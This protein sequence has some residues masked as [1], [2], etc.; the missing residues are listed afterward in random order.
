VG[1]VGDP[2]GLADGDA[3]G[4]GVGTT[5]QF[6]SAAHSSAVL[7]VHSQSL[8]DRARFASQHSGRAVGPK[9]GE[10][11][12]GGDGPLEGAAEGDALGDAEGA[13]EGAADG[14]ADG[15]ADGT[16]GEAEGDAVGVLVGNTQTSVFAENPYSAPTLLAHS[17][18]SSQCE[19]LS[20]SPSPLAHVHAVV[21]KL[22]DPLHFVLWHVGTAHT[23]VPDENS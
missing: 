3:V 21:Q 12:G 16:V 22:P 2:L 5:A 9:V 10:S 7:P 19:S 1:V 23:S 4:A 8:N 6:A 20:Q 18:P 15:A 14:T 11:V 17:S 13:D